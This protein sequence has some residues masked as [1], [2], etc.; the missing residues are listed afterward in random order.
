MPRDKKISHEK[1]IEAAKEEF[2]EYGYD[3]SSMR[4]IGDRCGL[5]AAALYRHFD[6]KEAMFNALVS[7]AVRD[8][9]K[10]LAEHSSE[11]NRTGSENIL[12]DLELVEMMEELVYPRM[13]EFTLLINKAGGSG[14]D[15]FLH[16]LVAD[17]QKKISA[18]I[19][20]MADSGYD[21]AEISDAELHMLMSAYCTALFEPVVHRYSLEEAMK[22]LKTIEAFFRPGW[23][24]LMG[25]RD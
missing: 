2:T 5:T 10:W 16:D 19:K 1:I 25:I 22:Y 23:R 12:D 3:K 24:D 13:D 8:L 11:T 18:Y 17:H 4:R 7:P 15:N 20:D 14:Y 9:E 21:V 6:S